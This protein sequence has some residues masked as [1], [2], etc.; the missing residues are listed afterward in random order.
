MIRA[1][2]RE[3]RITEGATVVEPTSGNRGIA[4]AYVCAARGYHLVL[5]MPDSMRFHAGSTLDR[6]RRLLMKQ[7]RRGF[8]FQCYQQSSGAGHGAFLGGGP[9]REV[10][11]FLIVS[12]MAD[13]YLA[14][15]LDQRS[16]RLAA[17]VRSPLP[18]TSSLF[19]IASLGLMA[20]A[21]WVASGWFRVL[22]IGLTVLVFFNVAYLVVQAFRWP[23]STG[24]S[25]QTG[26]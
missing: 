3:E 7:V 8:C 16:S 4:L 1:A 17:L 5:T 11:P 20:Q 14:R 23:K 25:D 9:V 13:G 21:D 22:W 26:N 2:E 24:R 15:W 10:L 19:I 18:T 12:D 6:V